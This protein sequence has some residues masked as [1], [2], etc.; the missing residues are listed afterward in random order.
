MSFLPRLIAILAMT[1]PPG[2]VE[3][4][5]P[6]GLGTFPVPQAARGDAQPACQAVFRTLHLPCPADSFFER[7]DETALEEEDPTKVEDH[8]IIPLTLLDYLAPLASRTISALCP[9]STC[10]PVVVLTLIL[11]C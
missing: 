10:T 2:S 5:E 3:G 1:L 11:R 4:P 8:G 7:R 6:E 9:F